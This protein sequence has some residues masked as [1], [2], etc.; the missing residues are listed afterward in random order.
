MRIGA[1][2]GAF[3]KRIAMCRSM[4]KISTVD[5]RSKRTLVVEGTLT[6]PWV[7]ELRTTCVSASQ[8]P[9]ERE[10]VIDL[11]NLT[12]ISREGEDA[13]FDLMKKGAKFSRGGI[14]T[15]AHVETTCTEVPQQIMSRK[16][17]PTIAPLGDSTDHHGGDPCWGTTYQ[18]TDAIRSASHD[19]PSADAPSAEVTA[20]GAC[21]SV[22][23]E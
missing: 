4:F 5:T 8:T 9:G 13:I 12:F 17:T 7:D 22:C 2:G 1:R 11:S 15:R 20:G 16:Q 23:R 3:G 10:L 21:L 14:L 18:E 19:A 6:G